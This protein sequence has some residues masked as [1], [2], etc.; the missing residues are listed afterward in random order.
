MLLAAHVRTNHIHVVVEA[1]LRPERV[2]NDLKPYA[3]RYLNQLGL[4]EPARKSWW[5][6][7]PV[8]RRSVHTVA[9]QQSVE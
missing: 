3:S 8:G 9:P 7:K 2:M 4:D 1:D 6:W 5:L